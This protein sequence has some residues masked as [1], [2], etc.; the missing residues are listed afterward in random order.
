MK[1]RFD[2]N[3]KK[4][5][6]ICLLFSL[7]IIGTILI[8][9]IPVSVKATYGQTVTTDDGVIIYFNV[10]EPVHGDNVKDAII[11]GHGGS[12][13]KEFM[14]GYAIEMAAA[15]FVAVT[16]DFRGH[17]QSTGE[18]DFALLINDVR[19]IKDEYLA[20]RGDI[21]MS[22]LGYLGYSMGGY[23][24]NEIV[25]ADDDFKLLIL[26]G[27]SLTIKKNDIANRSLN[28]LMIQARFDEGH[29]LEGSKAEM[30]AWLGMNAEDIQVN[31][32]YGEYNANASKIYLDDNS[33][34]LTLAW[35]TDFS[36]EARNW[37]I[38][39]FADVVAPDENFYGHIRYI[40]LLVQTIGGLG[41][42][43]L[44][45]KQLTKL[46][47]KPRE[48]ETIK[49][50]APNET[51]RSLPMKILIYGLLFGLPGM[52]IMFWV[53][54][55]LPLVTAGL[56]T[57]LFFGQVLGTLILLYR[58]AKKS[59]SSLK[60]YLMKP[61]KIPRKLLFKNIILG[62]LLGG[63]LYL[64]L[65]LTFGLN[66]IGM[67]PSII[68]IPWILV[69]F[70][71]ILLAQIIISICLQLIYQAKLQN[72]PKGLLK[73][74]L[75]GFLNHVLFLYTYI[76]GFGIVTNNFFTLIFLIIATPV[77]LLTNFILVYAYKNSGN[78]IA[79]AIIAAFI[80]TCILC[81]LSPLSF[82]ISSSAPYLTM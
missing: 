71:L 2:K 50:E 56:F 45:I 11:I 74:G 54:F 53:L 72:K 57:M 48:E 34:H 41:F 39:T 20:Q 79:G 62:L 67:I 65:N 63:I 22:N 44:I 59:N 46:I 49:I 5:A 7:F 66:Y 1:L 19:A 82:S 26:V 75:F 80:I 3:F 76:I 16:L 12:A 43:F 68:K 36:R 9:T 10:Y 25:K 17:G 21:N 8:F 13:N 60:T 23:P 37:V 28:I 18:I 4:I 73:T 24:G 30:G 27:S 6:L 42:F 52:F 29:P 61:F 77:A 81:T 69:Y 78:I 31:K 40:I 32:L 58:I 70:A 35:D 33:D 55:V 38:N 15:G 64:I 47:I 51:T 14:K